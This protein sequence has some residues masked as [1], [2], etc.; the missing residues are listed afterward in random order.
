MTTNR[1][2]T[3]SPDLD[4]VFGQLSDDE[5]ARVNELLARAETR[6][7]ATHAALE[8]KTGTTWNY[9]G[10]VLETEYSG[11]ASIDA[12][13]EEAGGKVTFSLQ[14][15]PRN[16]Y[17]TEEE[18]WQPGM[19][20]LQMA[21]DA[22]DVEGGV[23][24]RF[25]TRVA[26]RPYTIQEPVADIEEKRY[27][28]AVAAAEAFADRADELADLADSREPTVDAWRPAEEEST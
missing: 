27:E 9:A 13:I 4:P 15:R 3:E 12:E 2:S 28:G 7:T 18:M 10:V 23:A 6:L 14:L 11:Q 17:P 8:E 1:I 24:V 22:W 21:T 5:R 26:G 19:P 16:F 20:P 25:K